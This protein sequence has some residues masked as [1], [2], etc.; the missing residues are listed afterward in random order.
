MLTEERRR[1]TEEFLY[2]QIPL[3]RTMQVRVEKYDARGFTLTAPL[4]ANHNHLGTA[5]GGSLAA[6][7]ILA[8]Y[9]LLWLELNDRG[10]HLVI[11]ES[12]IKFRRPVRNVIRAICSR[13]DSA[14]LEKFKKDFMAKGKARVS[15]QV[16]IEEEGETAAS[17]EGTYVAMAALENF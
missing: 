3:S 17:F 13:P 11:S 12:R 15:L 16:T 9:G 5:F 14:A 10:A 2:R 4:S 7:M 8:G 6:L 1:A